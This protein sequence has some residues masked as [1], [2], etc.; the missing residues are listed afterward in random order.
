M[1][2]ISPLLVASRSP[3]NCLSMDILPTGS[4]FPDCGVNLT[5]N[6]PLE[7]VVTT[8]H[9]PVSASASMSFHAASYLIKSARLLVSA[10]EQPELSLH[11]A[12][13]SGQRGGRSLQ[14]HCSPQ[15]HATPDGLGTG[16]GRSHD[17]ARPPCDPGR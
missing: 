5:S 11:L 12:G 17:C 14:Q 13:T 16:G 2:S 3:W 10:E 8:N 7:R 6:D 15:P 1:L 9:R 4:S